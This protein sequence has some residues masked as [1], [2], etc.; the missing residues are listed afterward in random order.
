MPARCTSRRS[1]SVGGRPCSMR[2]R[3]SGSA[4]ACRTA[5]GSTHCPGAAP[6]DLTAV[7]RETSPARVVSPL[8]PED[9]RLEPRG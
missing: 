1:I 2:L 3:R 8:A 4:R 6:A 7:G 9:A 5:R